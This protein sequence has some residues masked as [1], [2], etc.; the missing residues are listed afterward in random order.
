MLGFLIHPFDLQK[1]LKIITEE[2]PAYLKLIALHPNFAGCDWSGSCD[3]PVNIAIFAYSFVIVAG[4]IFITIAYY[5]YYKQ[6][7]SISHT[8]KG[9][10]SQLNKM[11]FRTMNIQLVVYFILIGPP[12]FLIL[13]SAFSKLEYSGEMGQISLFFVLLYPPAEAIILMYFIKHKI[14]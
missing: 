13:F 4:L 11:L 8:L 1:S 6:T 3:L 14:Y 12:V 9:H 2:H 7:Q 5:L 10:T